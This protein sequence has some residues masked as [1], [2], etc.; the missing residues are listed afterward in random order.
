MHLHKQLLSTLLLTSLLCISSTSAGGVPKEF[1]DGFKFEEFKQEYGRFYPTPKEEAHAFDC[2]KKNLK[3]AARLNYEQSDAEFG[4][5]QYS[6]LCPE[7]FKAQYLQGHEKI[8]SGFGVLRHKDQDSVS[9]M[10][11]DAAL[12]ILS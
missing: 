10:T 6:D 4:V 2:F 12:D 7:E 3:I 1:S 5:T 9:P 11:Y 8:N